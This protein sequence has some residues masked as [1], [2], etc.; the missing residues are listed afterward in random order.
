MNLGRREVVRGNRGGECEE[1]RLQSGFLY[2]RRIKKKEKMFLM[3][4]EID[5]QYHIH[6]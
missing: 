1:G 2:E 4:Q 5:L 3:Y 6:S